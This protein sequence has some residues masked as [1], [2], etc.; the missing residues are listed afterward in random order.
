MKKLAFAIIL[1]LCLTLLLTPVASA[2]G[3]SVISKTGDG[4][5]SGNNWQVQMYPA[6]TKFAVLTLYNSSS[7]SLDVEASVSPASLDDGNVTFEVDSPAFT[8]L[9][10]AYA[11]ITLSAGASGSATPGVYEA[12]FELKF[13]IAPSGGGGGGGGMGALEITDI[14]VTNI[15]ETTAE[16]TWRTNRGATTKLTYWA[17]PE[18]VVRDSDF[19]A[20]HT[21]LLERLMACTEYQFEIYCI[22]NYGLRDTE[23]SE[24]KT[25]CPAPPAT[26]T[27]EI[28]PP[29]PPVTIPPTTP[30]V[31]T[32]PPETTPEPEAGFP[33]VSF[34]WLLAV[35]IVCAS[36]SVW[37][38]ITRRRKSRLNTQ[39]SLVAPKGGVK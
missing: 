11:D 37:W 14:K 35:V 27:P 32:P 31:T 3:I 20:R 33:W 17:S 36:A 4:T 2:A 13:E 26:S 39:S 22:D 25:F 18:V 30:P 29:P 12:V 15:T 5:W 16:I 28:T 6:E 8:M 24:F 7:S 19:A 23:K 34:L 38:W 1:A 21:M 9:G 10:K